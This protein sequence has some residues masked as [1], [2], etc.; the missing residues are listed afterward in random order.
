M[1]DLGVNVDQ[2]APIPGR[3]LAASTDLS[4]GARRVACVSSRYIFGPPRKRSNHSRARQ[5]TSSRVPG[6]SKRCEAP[7]TMASLAVAAAL[8]SGHRLAVECD[9]LRIGAADDQECGGT[10]ASQRLRTGQVG[11]ASARD[12]GAD[13][14]GPL[15]RRDQRRAAAGAGPEV[16]DFQVARLGLLGHPIGGTQE[17]LSQEADVEAE[18]ASHPFLKLFLLR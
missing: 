14:L 8:I 12:H 13:G 15:G 9:D 17:P 10:D 11:T 2:E 3:G 16:A 6:S 5:A 18:M 1:S 7:G 4:S